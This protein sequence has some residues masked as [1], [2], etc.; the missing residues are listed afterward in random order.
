[1]EQSIK[2]TGSPVLVLA[3]V[4]G[5]RVEGGYPAA[6]PGFRG[7]FGAL[8]DSIFDSKYI[9]LYTR[10]IVYLRVVV[11]LLLHGKKQS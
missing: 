7:F 3:G 11:N 6:I 8:R 2:C 4:Q 5:R 10:S 9:R 1:M